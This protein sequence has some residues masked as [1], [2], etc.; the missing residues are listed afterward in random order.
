MEKCRGK[1][2]HGKVNSQQRLFAVELFAAEVVR[3]IGVSQNLCL[4]V[5]DAIQ[6]D[7]IKN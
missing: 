7:A 5:L 2:P 1:V 6:G 4:A 3:R